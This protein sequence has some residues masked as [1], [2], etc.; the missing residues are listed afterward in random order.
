MTRTGT[1]K[2]YAS[3]FAMRELGYK[4]V[5]F[6]VHREQ[7]LKQAERSYKNVLG[8]DV[9]TGLLTGNHKDMRADYLFSTVQTMNKDYM[10][11][12]FEQD[13]F[14]CIIIDETHKA[15]AESYHKII[16]YFKPKLLLGMTASPERTDGFDIYKLFNHNIASEIR[17]QDA[18]KENLLCPF[19]YFGISDLTVNGVEVDE[20]TEFRY[21]ASDQRVD[22]I[23]EQA[24][25]FGHSGDRVK[26]L[27]FCSR[28]DEARALS[29]TFK[30]KGYNTMALS[31]DN[32]Q[33]EREKAIEHLES[34]CKV[35]DFGRNKDSNALDYIFTVD[36]FNEGV[37]IPQVNQVIMLRPTQSAIIFVQQLGRGLRKS[38]NKELLNP[39]CIIRG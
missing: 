34:D 20:K 12:N 37:D 22:H 29:E 18:L 11:K 25:Y 21:L 5:L 17:L 36:I 7:I 3:A 27:I 14:E 4:K 16:D 35:D 19:H 13:K 31:G 32:S 24:T 23:I 30:R 1:G 39:N 33:V 6:L 28:N 9:T 15:G 2:T 26:G 38:N 8:K 10:L